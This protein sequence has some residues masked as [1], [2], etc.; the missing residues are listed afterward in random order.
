MTTKEKEFSLKDLE[1]HL[2]SMTF[3][4]EHDWL[5]SKFGKKGTYAEFMTS[6]DKN[7]KELGL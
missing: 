2:W 4:S 6:I 3:Q 7:L 5:V 1:G